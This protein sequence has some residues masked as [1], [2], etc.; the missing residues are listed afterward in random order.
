MLRATPVNSVGN[1]SDRETRFALLDLADLRLD[2]AQWPQQSAHENR[3]G[4]QHDQR[5]GREPANE[6]PPET[7]NLGIEGV[8]GS[9]RL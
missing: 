5:D 4:Q 2:L 1:F 8:R 3:N 7:R 6:L 9:P